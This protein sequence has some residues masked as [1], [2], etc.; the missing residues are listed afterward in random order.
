MP[1]KQQLGFLISATC[2]LAWLLTVPGFA[3]DSAVESEEDLLLEEV[4]VTGTRI[5]TV[6]GFGRTSPV[7]VVDM[8]EIESFGYTRVEEFLNTLP[9]VQVSN[10]S[11]D[12]NE[13]TGTASLNLRG[14]GAERNLV[15]INGRRVQPGGV[16]SY[17]PDINQIPAQMIERVEVLTGGASATYGADAVAGVV[18]FIMRRVDGVELSVGVNGYQHDNR[19]SYIQGLMDEQGFDYPTGSDGVDGK[20][21]NVSIVIGDDFGDGR[22]NAT[23]YATWRKNAALLYGQRDYSSC[24]LNKEGNACGG[25]YTAEIPNFSR[26]PMA[27]ITTSLRS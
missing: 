24:A 23:A 1:N 18:N 10:S 17:A 6:D 8:Q 3:Q 2:L 7:T 19:N 25:S 20:S 27:W 13:A 26:G 14:L 5:K 4:I 16:Y 15:L 22:G 11:F 21:Y 9:Q 12:S